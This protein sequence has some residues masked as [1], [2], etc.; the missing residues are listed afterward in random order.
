MF[1]SS[2]FYKFPYRRLTLFD[3]LQLTLINIS[4]LLSAGLGIF[5]S[6]LIFHKHRES[7][8]NK[9]LSLLLL[10]YSII[11]IRLLLWDLQYYL[12]I[13]HW[14]LLPTS[15]TFLMGPVH[16][17]YSKYLMT[18]EKNFE[19][20]DWLHLIPFAIYLLFISKDLLKSKAELAS[21]LT[22]ANEAAAAS[23]FVV[24]NWLITI[25]ILVYI[26]LTLIHIKKYSASIKQV[27]S[28]IDKVKLNWLRDITLLIGFGIVVFLVENTF[29][30][31]GYQ[32]SEYFGLSN[33]IFCLYVIV[34]GYMGM[35]K[36]EIFVSEEFN[37]S[38]HEISIL[39]STRYESG[40]SKEKHYIKSG[41]TDQKAEEILLA[42]KQKM[43]TEKPYIDS[44]LTLNKLAEI[45]SVTPHN[46]SETINTKL[47]QNFFDYINSFRVEEVKKLLR[48]PAKKNYTLLAIAMEAG[49]NSKSSFNAIFKKFTGATPSEFRKLN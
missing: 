34:L 15:V 40:T 11:F 31:G 22:E 35:L 3:S 45:L 39:K 5:L 47:H 8:A 9:L 2:S 17:F 12:I 7:L 30:L 10:L 44:S 32:L 24:F 33:V 46:L 20:K 41:L 16:F 28:S 25:H 13:P 4:L 49:F 36:S 6:V 23:E 29:M 1:A 37:S 38:V 27:F 14:L 48:D 26:I 42:L 18:S 19:K 43:D 21:L